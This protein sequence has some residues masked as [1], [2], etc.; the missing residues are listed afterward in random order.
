[1]SKHQGPSN[2]SPNNTDTPVAQPRA[3]I[4]PSR[5]NNPYLGKP[6][7]GDP[8]NTTPNPLIIRSLDVSNEQGPRDAAPGQQITPTS[9]AP[10]PFED[11]MDADM[12]GLT[13]MSP[14]V[15]RRSKSPEPI[16]TGT[17]WPLAVDTTTEPGKC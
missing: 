12:S 16:S 7:E 4:S 13:S 5:R 11:T 14:S 3:T 10:Q 17:N 6:N 8:S 15:L 9:D 1:M 2:Q